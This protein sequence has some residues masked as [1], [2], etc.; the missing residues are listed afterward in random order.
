MEFEKVTKKDEAETV[1]DRTIILRLSDADCD[2]LANLSGEYG[3]TV[4]ELLEN[5]I[6]DLVD[7]TFSNG[8]DEIRYARYWFERCW[9][10]NF[11][12]NTLLHH[13][14]HSYRNPESYLDLFDEIEC[15]KE[16][17]KYIEEHPEEANELAQYIDDD[18]SSYEESL[19]DMRA[20]WKPEKIFF[21]L[22]DQVEIIRKFVRDRDALIYQ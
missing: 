17:K 7:G 2:R 19:H 8:S 11:P 20:G 1:R 6:G 10:Y 9:F 18:I 13:L 14:L 22:H 4:S 21:N 16:E 12:E 15:L 5:F 3:L